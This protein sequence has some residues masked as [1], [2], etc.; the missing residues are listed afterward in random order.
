[1][2]V[3]VELKLR[4]VPGVEARLRALGIQFGPSLFQEDT[5]LRHPQRDL[6]AADEA[7]RVRRE[8]DAWE[9]TYKGPRQEGAGKARIEQSVR[10]G[11]DPTPIFLALGFT[12]GPVVRKDRRTA[13]WDG[14][15]LALDEVEGLGTFL[16]IEVL[17]EG[18]VAAARRKVEAAARRLGLDPAK[19]ERLAYVQMLRPGPS[20]LPPAP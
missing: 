1:V 10:T 8:G 7:L 19:E 17:T 18:D 20:A 4:A 6:A 16:E 12:E 3:E 15:T 5:F 13:A 14:V 11:A 2:P 9:L